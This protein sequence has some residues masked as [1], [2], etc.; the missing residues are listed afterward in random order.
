MEYEVGGHT[1]FSTLVNNAAFVSFFTTQRHPP[2]RQPPHP[3][4]C[5]FSLS[6]TSSTSRMIFLLLFFHNALHEPVLA[7]N[8]DYFFVVETYPGD[9]VKQKELEE[10]SDYAYTD[11]DEY[12][13]KEEI[14]E[15]LFRSGGIDAEVMGKVNSSHSSR[16]ATVAKWTSKGQVML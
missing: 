7:K 11:D 12:E 10:G 9:E 15:E 1:A 4:S 16:S 3:T 13:Y 2:P 5:P 8:Y 14:D 6:A